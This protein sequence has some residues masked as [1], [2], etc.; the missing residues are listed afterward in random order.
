M[1]RKGFTG[2]GREGGKP[3]GLYGGCNSFIDLLHA[4]I[5]SLEIYLKEKF[6]WVN[7]FKNITS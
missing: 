7:I 4:L 1:V 6:Y 5:L 2:A 3:L